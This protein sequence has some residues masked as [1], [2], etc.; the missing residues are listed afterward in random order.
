MISVNKQ[1][2][3]IHACEKRKLLFE[4]ICAFGKMERGLFQAMAIET[5]HALLQSR[6]QKA[7]SQCVNDKKWAIKSPS[8]GKH[9]L[10]KVTEVHILQI[11][12]LNVILKL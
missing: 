9:R 3:R 10:E 6:W 4:G 5:K 2:Q 1:N 7:A 12:L 8:R 11:N